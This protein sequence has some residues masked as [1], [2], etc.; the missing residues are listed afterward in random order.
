MN[1]EE[2]RVNTTPEERQAYLDAGMGVAFLDNE[3]TVFGQVIEGIDIIDKIAIQRT[4]GNDRPKDDIKMR[5][6]VEIR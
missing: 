2:V 5:M 6:R 4:D 1:S 3:Y